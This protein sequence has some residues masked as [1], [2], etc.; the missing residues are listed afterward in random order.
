MDAA[1]ALDATHIKVA[2]AQPYIFPAIS[3]YQLVRCS[4]IFVLYDDANYITRGFINRNT[5]MVR[6]VPRRF[7]LPVP[8]ASINR[9]IKD[10]QFS[11]DVK[12]VIEGI[13]H[14]YSRAPYF[15]DVFPV[16]CRVLEYRDRDITAIC[17][18][19]I[20]EVFNYLGF[21]VIVIRSAELEYDRTLPA[22]ERLMEIC[23]RMG[24]CHYIN[25]QGGKKLYQKDNFSSRGIRLS[26]LEPR[27]FTYQQGA[28]SF[29]PQLSIVDAL[30]RCSRDEV[31]AMLD[32]Y[33]LD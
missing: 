5:Y 25:S 3:Y 26:F 20:K 8:G 24:G 14:A 31:R 23:R 9:K 10:L 12:D 2:V 17:R 21:P 16:I 11:S 15:K 28:E 33:D 29:V 27:K 13:R 18:E 32:E 4:D 30:M 6:G 1:L 19:G 7:T 22:D